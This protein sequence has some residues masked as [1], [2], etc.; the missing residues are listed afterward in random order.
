MTNSIYW[1]RKQIF[2]SCILSLMFPW[3]GYALTCKGL[4]NNLYVCKPFKCIEFNPLIPVTFT[5]HDI[6]GLRNDKCIYQQQSI[7]GTLSCAYSL[8][9]RKKIVSLVTKFDEEYKSQLE[10]IF[11]ES[12][13]T[14][15]LQSPDEAFV[16]TDD[17][18][19]DC[20]FVTLHEIPDYTHLTIFP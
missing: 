17:L 14:S 13:T 2:L 8:S 19:N 1:W 20:D 4:Y 3:S 9:T 7:T 5:R 12:L 6:K 10:Q 15:N 11:F 16:N 18:L